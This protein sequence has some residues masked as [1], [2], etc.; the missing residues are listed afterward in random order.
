M[1]V[2][3]TT[4]QLHMSVSPKK[5]SDFRRFSSL[6]ISRSFLNILENWQLFDQQFYK[7]LYVSVVETGDQRLLVSNLHKISYFINK[8]D[9]F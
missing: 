1:C 6:I 9:S 3:A 4:C 7:S 8:I 2:N 5:T